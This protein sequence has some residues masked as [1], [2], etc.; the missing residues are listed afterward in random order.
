[1][2]AYSTVIVTALALL[3]LAG[4]AAPT[5]YVQAAAGHLELLR[6]REPLDEVAARP[7]TDPRLAARLQAAAAARRFAIDQLGLPD[8]DNYT[9]FVAT[10]REAVAW[11]VIATPEFSLEPR[12][13]CFPVAGCVPYRGYF[14]PDDARRF[15]DRLRQRGDDVAV[16]P[17]LAYST[18]GWFEDPL[19]DTMLRYSDAQLAAT[20]FHEMAHTRL[21]VRGDAAF[22]EA[23]AS[24]VEARGVERWLAADGAGEELAAWR[25]GRRAERDF[26]DLL[27]AAWT[28]LDALYRGAGDPDTLRAGKQAAFERLRSGYRERVR[29]R[30]AGVDH[31]AAWFR[32]DLNNARLALSRTYTGGEC[33]FAG[34]F[35]EAGG[36]FRRFYRLA[37][38]QAARGREARRAWLQRPCPA[39]APA[40]DL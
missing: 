36:D 40:G 26:R 22:N 21:Y 8:T 5:Y 15:A 14:D 24:F 1:V 6:Q 2:P 33:A 30:W 28:E 23:F 29:D 19:L 32:D 37:E 7:D 38:A 10:G 35:A 13:W 27:A 11:N 16:A 17:A 3:G 9:R 34:L 18:L 20:L 12:R 31:F 25:R 39:I 4:C